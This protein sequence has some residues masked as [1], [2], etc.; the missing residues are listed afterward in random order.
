[1]NFLFEFLAAVCAAC[2]FIGALHILLPEGNMSKSLKYILCLVFLVSVISASGIIVK[3]TDFAN[4]KKSTAALVPSSLE[5]ETESARLVYSYAL[6]KS[7]IEFSEINI[8]TDKRSDDSIYISKVTKKTECNAETVND[9]LG[10][11][12]NNIRIE[13]INE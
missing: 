3:N 5:L 13:V 10:D 6:Q 1:M 12:A 11:A 8:L 7:G 4:F 9:A 2:V